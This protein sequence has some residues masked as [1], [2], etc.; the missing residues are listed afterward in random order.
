MSMWKSDP[1]PDRRWRRWRNKRRNETDP[2]R[3]LPADR[4]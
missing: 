3:P 4:L 2:R 1:S